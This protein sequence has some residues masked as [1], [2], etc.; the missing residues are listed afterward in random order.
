MANLILNLK[1]CRIKLTCLHHNCL[2]ELSLQQLKAE[3]GRGTENLE[4]LTLTTKQKG[5][6][7]RKETEIKE[8]TLSLQTSSIVQEK[9][10]KTKNKNRQR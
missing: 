8:L 6:R 3:T 1:S 10:S 5:E 2:Q 9:Q 7:H 4:E